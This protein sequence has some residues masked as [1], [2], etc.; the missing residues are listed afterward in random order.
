MQFYSQLSKFLF[1]KK[2][3]MLNFCLLL[4]LDSFAFEVSWCFVLLAKEHFTAS[5][6]FISF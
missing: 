1:L 3:I 4:C 5:L 6:Q 2:K